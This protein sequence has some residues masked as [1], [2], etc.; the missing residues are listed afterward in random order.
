MI[1]FGRQENKF[2][3]SL[4][5]LLLTFLF[6]F[7]LAGQL[8]AQD[9]IRI[10][11]D[12][13]TGQVW[14]PSPHKSKKTEPYRISLSYQ[15]KFSGAYF[16]KLQTLEGSLSRKWNNLFPEIFYSLTTG[17]RRDLSEETTFSQKNV[18]LSG[19]G[20]GLSHQSRMIQDFSKIADSFESITVGFGYYFLQQSEHGPG[21]KTDFKIYFL[22]SSSLHYGLKFSYHLVHL[23]NYPPSP[24][25][26][27]LDAGLDIAYYF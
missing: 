25:F 21:L 1:P 23:F 5:S 16:A 12:P 15:W 3:V 18:A 4:I 27:W 13:L 17:P 11:R 6:L 20:V 2:S 19:F 8:Q 10:H 7:P 14:T 24:F 9:V 26:S 22:S